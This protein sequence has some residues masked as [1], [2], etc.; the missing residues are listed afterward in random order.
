[1]EDRENDSKNTK[2]KRF[3]D[4]YHSKCDCTFRSI[5]NGIRHPL[6]FNFTFSTPPG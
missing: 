3:T 1:M 4:M 5:V 2:T 6:L